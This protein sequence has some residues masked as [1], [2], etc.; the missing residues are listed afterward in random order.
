[1]SVSTSEEK[2]EM[3]SDSSNERFSVC[4]QAILYYCFILLSYITGV[5]LWILWNF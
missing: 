5:F 2:K 1:M 4:Q 3:S